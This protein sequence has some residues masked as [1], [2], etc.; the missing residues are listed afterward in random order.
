[1]VEKGHAPRLHYARPCRRRRPRA[2]PGSE[3]EGGADAQALSPDSAAQT[4]ADAGGQP[5]E[6]AAT[7]AGADAGGQPT[8]DAATHAGADAGEQTSE[9]AATHAGAD[10]GE[11][12]SEDA[13]THDG[14]DAGEQTSEDASTQA[15]SRFGRAAERGRRRARPRRRR[16]ADSPA[17]AA[18]GSESDAVSSYLINASPAAC[19][20]FSGAH[21]PLGRHFDIDHVSYHT[22]LRSRR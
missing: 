4:G 10:A 9:D 17:E 19:N 22:A 21:V 5:T 15:G 20:I 13:A 14:A 1:V 18:V 16:R 7:H 8:E 2:C 6:D 12:T 11:Q 3:P